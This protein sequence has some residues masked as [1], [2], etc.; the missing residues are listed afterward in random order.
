MQR[1]LISKNLI[2]YKF[3]SPINNQKF[4]IVIS[5]NLG[6][7]IFPIK[8]EYNK[9]LDSILFG[10]N[11]LY[12][13]FFKLKGFGYKWKYFLTVKKSKQIIFL[14]V[15]FTH[16]IALITKRNSLLKLKKQRLII[17]HRSYASIRNRL[18][19]LFFLYKTHLYNMKGI[20]LRGTKF[21]V[22]LSKKKS[23]F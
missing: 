13:F 8:F 2:M 19:F 15:G 7:L 14:K 9:Q 5:F 3:L 23:K 11:R 6:W 20:Y 12:K 4:L 17:K 22:K 18:N 16:R 21:K 10:Y 1:N